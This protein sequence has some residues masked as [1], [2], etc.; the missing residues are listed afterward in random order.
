MTVVESL[1]TVAEVAE[2]LWVDQDTVRRMFIDEPGVIV[3]SVESV[4]RRSSS[5]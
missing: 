2:Q 3:R 1:F 5:R 4:P